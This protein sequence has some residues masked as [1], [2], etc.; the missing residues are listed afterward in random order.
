[1]HDLLDPDPPALIIVDSQGDML[2]KIQRLEIF[3]RDPDR[4]VIIDPEHDPS[5]N[6]FDMATDRLADYS[7]IVRE[8]VEAG[9]IELYT[10]V[11]GAIASEL[12]AKQGTAF[13]FVVRLMLSIPGATLHTLLE[14]M[15]DPSKSFAESP[16]APYGARLD[17]TA[18]SFFENQFFNK[19]AFGTDAAADRPPALRR[20]LR[21][22][23]R[24]HV[25]G[26]AQQAR[27]VRRDSGP[28]GG[29]GQHREVASEVRRLGAVRPLHDRA[30]HGRRLRARRCPAT[31]SASPPTSSSTR[32]PSISTT[33]WRA[34]CRR[35]ANSSSASCSP[36]STW[37][38]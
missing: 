29:V 2:D 6:M 12:T 9:I 31:T 15:E 11:F 22:G 37:S 7:P 20:P 19:Q 13:A 1:M 27:H 30:G 18:R 8:Q 16:F 28:Q 10:Y 25:L 38:N 24:P 3:A 4:L 36:T 17:Q 5:L 32:R 33:A 34:C 23:V 21:P 35:R 14:L 26:Q